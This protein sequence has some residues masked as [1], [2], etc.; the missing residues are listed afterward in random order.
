MRG[1]WIGRHALAVWRTER[2]GVAFDGLVAPAGDETA[3]LASGR[4]G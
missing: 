4:L 1:C 2:L 3:A